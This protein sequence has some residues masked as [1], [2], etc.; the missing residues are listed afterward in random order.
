MVPWRAL[1][2][3]LTIAVGATTAIAVLCAAM[4]WTVSSPAWALLAPLAMWAP[5]LARFVAR[6]VDSRS[7]ATL[8]LRRWG[9]GGAAVILVPLGIPLLVYGAAYAV[10]WAAGWVQFSPGEG[11]WTTG[12]QIIANLLVNLTF[13][14]IFGTFTAMGEEIGWRGY[15]QPRLDE[16]GVRFS[17]VIVWLCQLAYHAPLM[18]GADYLGGD[19]FAATFGLFAIADLP[20]SFL[21][22]WLAY[23]AR[24]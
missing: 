23:R 5:A 19:S 15:L 18:L 6:A 21:L 24:T 13:L 14:G 7:A 2:V 12:S 9:E 4:G 3:F 16:A 20:V 1:I 8:T 22:A 11:R 10:A 17:V